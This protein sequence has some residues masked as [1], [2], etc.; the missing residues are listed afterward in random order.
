MKIGLSARLR[1]DYAS[2]QSL[3][4][5][6]ETEPTILTHPLKPLPAG[7]RWLG[8]AVLVVICGLLALGRLTTR[9]LYPQG[10]RDR[11]AGY[12]AI[13]PGQPA[14][15]LKVYNCQPDDFYPDI[16]AAICT[17]AIEMCDT[18]RVEVMGAE[19]QVAGLTVFSKRLTLA[20]LLRHWGQ[21]ILKVRHSDPQHWHL[22]WFAD[23]Y[24]VLG[25]F[26]R[27]QLTELADVLMF[28]EGEYPGI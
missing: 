9:L 22:K 15:N 8:W 21:P 12:D 25:S 7:S 13:M 6:H 19:E 20:D 10:Y 27:L 3:A 2:G 24:T 26:K 5:P 23:S 11:L 1:A 17:P 14:E 4:S 28:A 16:N 18:M